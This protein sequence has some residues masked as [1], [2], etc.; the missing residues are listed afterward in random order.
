M[1]RTLHII[2]FLSLLLAASLARAQDKVHLLELRNGRVLTV[3]D[4][5]QLQGATFDEV[6][7][8]QNLY[9]SM[10]RLGN[11]TVRVTS[12]NRSGLSLK[13]VGNTI[14]LADY[15]ASENA[16]F[17]WELIY[18]GYFYD[19]TANPYP[20]V[21]P[22][23]SLATPGTNTVLSE[24]SGNIVAMQTITPDLKLSHNKDSK[25]DHYRFKINIDGILL[26]ATKGTFH[27]KV[28][29]AW[30]HVANTDGYRIYRDNQLIDTEEITN[31][32]EAPDVIRY[33]DPDILPTDLHT[34]RVEGYRNND[35]NFNIQGESRGF[36]FPNGE[37]KGIVKTES[38]VFVKDVE[39]RARPNMTSDRTGS[40]LRF[41]RGQAPIK[42]NKVTAFRNQNRL[43]VEF[44]HRA[45]GIN[46][47]TPFKLGNN[48]IAFDSTTLTATNGISTL[49]APITSD[50]Q[51]HH[52]A[53]VFSTQGGKVYQDGQKIA[54]NTS[55][56][57]IRMTNETYFHINASSPEPFNLDELRVWKE[58][59]SRKTIASRYEH[60]LSGDEE[61]LE[62]YYRFDL[63]DTRQVYNQ[64]E[65]TKGSYI[66]KSDVNLS[67]TAATRQPSSLVY[68]TFTDAFGN[69]SL[70]S[71]H[72]GT[73]E[74]PVYFN[75][76]P[77]KPNHEFNI[78]H[79]GVSLRTSLNRNDYI[80]EQDFIASSLPVSGRI[81]YKVGEEVYPVP[82]GQEILIDGLPVNSTSDDIKTDA[83]GVYS[84]SAPLGIHTFEV[85]NQPKIRYFGN[86]S[87]SLDSTWVR[88]KKVLPHQDQFTISGWVKRGTFEGTI[89]PTQTILRLRDIQLIL[90]DNE[91]LI[92]R[93]QDTDLLTSDIRLGDQFAF[94]AFTV[95]KTENKVTLYVEESHQDN[96][97]A[98]IGDVNGYLKL[99]A[100][101]TQNNPTN[102]FK[103]YIDHLE[104]R[105]QVYDKNGLKDIKEGKLIAG[106]EQALLLSYAFEETKGDKAIS[107][108]PAGAEYYLELPDGDMRSN[109]HFANYTREYHYDYKASN[110]AYNPEEGRYTLNIVNPITEM[111]FENQTRFGFIGNIVVPCGYNV[112]SWQGTITR[113]D[114]EGFEKEIE[115]ADFNEDHTL[116]SID[117]L[118]P[119]FYR[120]TLTNTADPTKS[121]QSGIIDLTEGWK[122]HDFEYRDEL[123]IRTTLYTWDSD[124][125]EKGEPLAPL[126]NGNYELEAGKKYLVMV[127][128]YEQY[129]NG[130]CPVENATITIKG[131]M[132]S[133]LGSGFSFPSDATGKVAL[134]FA[135]NS[136]NFI[137]DT[138]RALEVT[139][140]HDNRN[141]TATL[142]AYNTGS[143]QENSNFTIETPFVSTVLHDPPGDN[144]SATLDQSY[145]F[146]QEYSHEKGTQVD[147]DFGVAAGINTEAEAG[148]A[149]A[150]KVKEVDSHVGLGTS[151]SVTYKTT[152]GNSWG[153][154]LNQAISTSSDDTFT[155]LD[156]DVYIGFGMVVKFGTGKTLTV[157]NCKPQI[158]NNVEVTKFVNPTPF[159]YTHQ[160]IKDVLLVQLEELKQDAID[161]GNQGAVANYAH[162]IDRWKSILD[163]NGVKRANFSSLPGFNP[164]EYISPLNSILEGSDGTDA[165]NFELLAIPR[166]ISF[167]GL[168][169]Q[170]YQLYRQN[171]TSGG[172]EVEGSSG[173][174]FDTEINVS[175]MGVSSKFKLNTKIIGFK[176]RK[177]NNTNAYNMGHSFTLSDDDAGD[178]FNVTIKRDPNYGTPIFQTTAGQ[179]SCPFE[180]GTQ[181]REG[182]EL[183]SDRYNANVL[184]GEAAVYNLTLRNTQIAV[185]NTPKRYFL[186]YNR[187]SNADGAVVRFN[188]DA[189]GNGLAIDFGLD[190][191]SP[192]GV[193][194]QLNG[195]LTITPPSHVTGDVSYEDIEVI[196]YSGCE[197]GGFDYLYHLDELAEVGVQVIDTIH[198]SAHFKAP[199]V[200]NIEVQAPINDW[201]VNSTSNDELELVFRIPGLTKGQA[202]EGLTAVQVEYANTENNTPILLKEI[203]LDT[204]KANYRTGDKYIHHTI[205]LGG[206][207]DGN[208]QIRLTPR[209]GIGNNIWRTSNA[210]EYIEGSIY[211]I[212]PV[213]TE[214][215]PAENSIMTTGTITA[216]YDRP[217]DPGDVNSLN[218]SLRGSWEALTMCPSQSALII[219]MT[220]LPSL[221][222]QPLI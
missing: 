202:P 89:P 198:L 102:G 145:S 9:F 129:A 175:I 74:G 100:D 217:I 130:E 131:D 166:N 63:K 218:V 69:Y 170:S 60:I 111:H 169:S 27:N 81:T 124:K 33:D 180:T 57:A 127:E 51:W 72:T 103:G 88:S 199:C 46:K 179:S 7:D 177:R 188:G 53:V 84:I 50:G 19:S 43:T 22:Y 56:F 76:R 6:E 110:E 142:T 34:Y 82:M 115:E 39:L 38:E 168:T 183:T 44:W 12:T 164:E 206:L 204:L 213:I 195:Q 222:R 14:V 186:A 148:I 121:M 200:A 144:S 62:L 26:T 162:Q 143:V 105:T 114:A 75:L 123:N 70:G 117:G 20:A 122:S 172:N 3:N 64:A 31:H 2:G 191:N 94:F 138:T 215:Y 221:T 167:S 18:A 153:Y 45:T 49:N 157:V 58:A 161:Q 80:K 113:T 52:Y 192:V 15:S 24:Q 108:T 133:L 135:A 86:Q 85:K 159:V 211:R 174:V 163:E 99:G 96:N 79:Q 4:Q 125:K 83:F 55:N 77:S 42:V 78:P 107:V 35:P 176:N 134:G 181:P 87:L 201:V 28:Q 29:L 67:W 173:L 71:I 156:A 11:N 13:R 54:S 126:C 48:H 106:D 210:T 116:F 128:A 187:G 90:K 136:P 160:D 141:T 214:V 5:N 139:A 197:Y 91:R 178:H 59:L 150:E 140:V 137:G 209:C 207:A 23:A 182:V 119:G 40:A 194:Q 152:G 154:T 118:L 219:I 216:S 17:A 32:N 47:S 220:R 73:G 66:G 185:D 21:H 171:S 65:T 146:A 8:L 93:N 158:D 101:G 41:L 165:T 190:D 205:D 208:Y 68:G 37:I 92:V 97:N 120:V 1:K 149:W 10:V 132:G 196:M 212:A 36:I 147:F 109:E 193:I 184:S 155:G 61:N 25:G 189:L 104:Y 16:A 151:T 203:N 98:T 95:D 30:P 112:G